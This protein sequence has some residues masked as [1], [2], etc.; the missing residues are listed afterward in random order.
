MDNA[1]SD[2]S[3]SSIPDLE[4]GGYILN[5]EILQNAGPTLIQTL[6]DTITEQIRKIRNLTQQLRSLRIRFRELERHSYLQAGVIGD[7][8][9][10]L[11]LDT[12]GYSSD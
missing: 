5:D 6:F 2:Y 3:L 7:L 9:Y 12:D 4:D 10:Q 1:D 11:D 8:R